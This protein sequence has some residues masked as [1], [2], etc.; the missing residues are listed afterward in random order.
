MLLQ[1]GIFTMG[2]TAQQA[3]ER[4]IEFVTLA[5]ERLQ[6]NRKPLERA[7]LPAEL[8][9]AAEIAPI[10][11]GAVAIAR[12]ELA[13]TVKRQI[14]DFRSSEA[15]LNYVNGAELAR[16]SQVGV[17]TPDHTI[18][19]KNWPLIVPA[20]EAGKLGAWKGEVQRGGRCLRRPL[21]RLFRAQQCEVRA[22]EDRAR[23]AAARRAGAGRRPVR[24][25]RL[26]QGCGHRRRHRREHGR[27]HHRCR[28]HRHLPAHRR[29]RPVR[30]GILV[31]GAGQAGQVGRK[32]AGASGRGR[33]RRRLA[34][35]ARPPPRRLRTRAP[36]SPS[37]TASLEAAQ[38]VAKQ[39][40]K[41]ALA[42]A[43]DV[44]DPASVRA[45]F[46]QVARSF[47][48]VD[49]VVSN[50][51]AAW[52]GRIGEVDDETLRKSFELNFFAHQSVAQNAVRI[53][54]RAGHGRVPAVQHLQAGGQSGHAISGPMAC[55]R[56]RRCS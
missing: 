35:S 9:A 46:D 22:E 10:L 54:T 48:G 27:G 52:Q 2:D 50:A 17:V 38:A 44:T 37:S 26:R 51:G 34:A 29:V 18:R 55:P 8:A 43:C 3:Y 33:H 53:M 16:Y 42:I 47:G 36:R 31:A 5:E 11:R 40:G 12:D 20:P 25:R 6:K 15:I 39:I 45:A 23:S 49:I 28:S 4:M 19:T 1:H 7:T 32:A 30:D 41:T 24:P 21:S 14:L 13:G 56:R